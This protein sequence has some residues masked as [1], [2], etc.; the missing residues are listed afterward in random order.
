VHKKPKNLGHHEIQ[1]ACTSIFYTLIADY[2][3]WICN[4]D[5]LSNVK[6]IQARKG[7]HSKHAVNFSYYIVSTELNILS[8]S[9]TS[10]F[11]TVP[12]IRVTKISKFILDVFMIQIR[13]QKFMLRACHGGGERY[14]YFTFSACFFYF[15]PQSVTLFCILFASSQTSLTI[16]REHRMK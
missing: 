7:R 11:K 10:V 4:T 2:M 13:S 14:L 1:L 9:G 3:V 12:N 15:S 16:F 6:M 5:V 8:I